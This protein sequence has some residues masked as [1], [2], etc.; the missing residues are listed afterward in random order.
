MEGPRPPSFT[1]FRFDLLRRG[2]IFNR[3]PF[4]KTANGS[5][6]PAAIWLAGRD[7]IFVHLL[8]YQAV[9]Y[10]LAHVNLNV[11]P[12]A[13]CELEVLNQSVTGRRPPLVSLLRDQYTDIAKKTPPG[14]GQAAFPD[15]PNSVE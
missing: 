7:S 8:S 15:H 14:V 6:L 12:C 9:R 1:G 10:V 4:A 13:L 2:A 5:F 3:E 11:W